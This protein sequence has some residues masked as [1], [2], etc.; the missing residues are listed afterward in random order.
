MTGYAQPPGTHLAEL[1]VARAVDDLTSPRLAGF[2]AALDR[3]NAL[4]DRSKGFV[5]RLEDATGNATGFSLDDDPRL[6]IN[7]SIWES[8]DDLA[9]FTFKTVH[10]R[11]FDRRADWFEPPTEAHLVMWWVAAGHRP[12]LKEA[13]ERLADLRDNGPSERAF[14]WANVVDLPA[15]D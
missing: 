11:I 10:R 15:R 6:I 2:V 12:R 4:A 8:A 1:N 13:A 14:G 5:W 9:A 7:L 3:V